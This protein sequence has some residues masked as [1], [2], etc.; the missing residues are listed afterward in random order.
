VTHL[1]LQSLRLFYSA[2]H[3]CSYLPQQSAN[4]LVVDPTASMNMTIYSQLAQLGFRRSGG[5]VYRPHCDHCSACIPV[6]VPVAQ[7]TPN[8]QQRRTQALNQDLRVTLTTN[9][10]L[11]RHS[12]LFQRYVQQRHHDGG[13]GNMSGD[14]AFRFLRSS[15]SDTLFV[16]FHQ[17]EQL[18][19]CAV[20]D[21]L[22]D[23]LS[24]VYSYF[25]PAQPKRSLG[26]LAV[27]Q[28]IEIARQRELPY[29]YLGYWIK[30]C[31]KMAYKSHY[32]P[33]EGYRG[34][35]WQPLDTDP[36]LKK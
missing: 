7:F 14:D 6:R 4:N 22:Q 16:E 18:L 31:R 24:A 17:D 3:P 5:Q 12:E 2:P 29:L 28:Q 21:C 13:M 10:D 36:L 32:R 27:L 23:G 1:S 8:R 11:E 34:K 26:V 30:D 25:D 35:T 33:L 20:A 15:W 9:P 19:T